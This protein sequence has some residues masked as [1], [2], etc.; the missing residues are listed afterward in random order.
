MYIAFLNSSAFLNVCPDPNIASRKRFDSKGMYS[1]STQCNAK[2]LDSIIVL[3]IAS[4]DALEE[5]NVGGGPLHLHILT[6][7]DYV[8]RKI[9]IHNI[10]NRHSC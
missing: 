6:K 4:H 8:M 5:G 2:P 7:L 3:G 1:L 9:D 10:L